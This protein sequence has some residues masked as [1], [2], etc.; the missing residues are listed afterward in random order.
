MQ[1]LPFSPQ[2]THEE[3]E[4]AGFIKEHVFKVDN[5]TITSYSKGVNWQLVV[6]L[7]GMTWLVLKCGWLRMC[8]YINAQPDSADLIH[9]RGL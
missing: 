8:E 7:N 2:A 1:F 6:E 3:V 5:K 9:C 4:Q